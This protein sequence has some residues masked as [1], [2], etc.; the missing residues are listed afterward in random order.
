MSTD[1]IAEAQ[2]LQQAGYFSRAE[3][4][5]REVLQATPN[6]AEVWFLLGDSLFHQGRFDEA[7]APFRRSIDLDPDSGGAYLNLS[8]LLRRR[9]DLEGAVAWISQP[10]AS[11]L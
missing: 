1:K 4:I 11:R 9:G 7:M 2:R 6:D 8:H 10:P 5:Y 3:A